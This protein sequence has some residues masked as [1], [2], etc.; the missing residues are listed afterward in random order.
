[1]TRPTQHVREGTSGCRRGPDRH[2]GLPVP[3][4]LLAVT[5]RGRLAQVGGA[6][7]LLARLEVGLCP[8][9]VQ[10]PEPGARWALAVCRLKSASF[11]ENSEMG[12][13]CRDRQGSVCSPVCLVY[14][15][16]C[17]GAS[18][19]PRPS[20]VSGPRFQGEQ[21][22]GEGDRACSGGAP[23]PG[24]LGPEASP[25]CDR[26]TVSPPEPASAPP[27]SPHGKQH[28]HRPSRST[29]GNASCEKKHLCWL[30][31]G[32]AAGSPGSRR[33]LP[34][35]EGERLQL[36]PPRRGRQPCGSLSRVSPNPPWAGRVPAVPSLCVL[37]MRT[38]PP[39]LTRARGC[40]SGVPAGPG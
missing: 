32:D 36:S 40:R 22:R 21:G 10:P 25:G 39:G 27:L 16:E 18:S 8:P 4:G 34:P 24:P 9:A 29:P 30:G 15:C 17:E 1:M 35:G 5:G 11:Q 28:R 14:R 19:A 13:G 31:F 20:S 26:A 38:S 12:R 23:G 6:G 3:V 2:L 7:T 33:V 37:T